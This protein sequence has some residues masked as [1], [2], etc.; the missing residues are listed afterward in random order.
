MLG[1]ESHFYINLRKHGLIRYNRLR[2]L[3][4]FIIDKISEKNIDKMNMDG[5]WHDIGNKDC[6]YCSDHEYPIECKCGGLIH[7]QPIYNGFE[8]KCDQCGYDYEEL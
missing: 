5:E 2:G 1:I 4:V 3:R 7:E 6:E 8:H